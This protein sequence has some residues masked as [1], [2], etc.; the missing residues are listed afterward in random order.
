LSQ[1]D[2]LLH[3]LVYAVVMTAAIYIIVD[4]EFPRIG[5]IRIDQSDALLAAQ[6]Q[7]MV[8]PPATAK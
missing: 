2:S 7:A 1:R 4:F 6:R 8:D 3:Q 5:T